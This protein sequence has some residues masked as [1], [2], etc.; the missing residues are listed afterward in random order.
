MPAC[1]KTRRPRV[2]PLSLAITLWACAP[3]LVCQH[4]VAALAPDEL[5]ELVAL[6]QHLHRHPELSLREKETSARMAEELQR[7]GVE[8]TRHV[9]GHGVVGLLRNGDGKTLMLRADMDALPVAE[10]TGL[11]YASA[12]RGESDEG[13]PVGI[14]HACGHD[15]HMTNLVGTVRWLVANKA[16]WHGTLLVVFQPAEEGGL[17]A[18]AMLG[19]KLFERF[20]RPDFALAL[21]TAHDLPTGSVGVRAG[22]AMANADSVDITVFGRGGHGSMPHLTI[23]PI[24]LAAYLI[25]DLQT[26]VSRELAATE[27]AVVSVGAI[28]AGSKHNIIPD[29]CELQLTVRSYSEATRT[30]IHAAIRRKAAAL[31]VAHRA[32]EPELAFKDGTPA[33]FNHEGLTAR[34]VPVLERALGKANVVEVPP[35]MGAED[36]S[37]YGLAGVPVFMF[38][39]GTIAPARLAQMAAKGEVPPTLHSARYYPDAEES[40]RTGIAAM[41]AA[42]VELLQ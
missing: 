23:D 20:V 33:L 41:T 24:T 31:A 1:M 21:H 35:V 2:V 19:D 8:V 38:R 9:G 29:R 17:G 5:H 11:P 12:I 37:R 30:H 10:E 22:W 34:V 26:I 16:R 27:P 32:P 25:T 15:L 13:R 14:M 7:A 18:K 42:A 6:Y 40:L 28:H 36:F 3:N 39:L 4:D